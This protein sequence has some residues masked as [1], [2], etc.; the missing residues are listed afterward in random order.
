MSVVCVRAFCSDERVEGRHH[1]AGGG[2]HCAASPAHGVSRHGLVDVDSSVVTVHSRGESWPHSGHGALQ[3]QRILGKYLNTLLNL[4]VLSCLL[5]SY[6][7]FFLRHMNVVHLFKPYF[8][9][10]YFNIIPIQH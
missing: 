8:C 5:I 2:G 6:L 3:R 7:E 1:T 10:I 9:K 4:E